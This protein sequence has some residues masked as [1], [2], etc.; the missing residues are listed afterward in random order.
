MVNYALQGQGAQAYNHMV[1]FTTN[2]VCSAW[3][4]YSTLPHRS[5]DCRVKGKTFGLT[6]A[7][8]G[9]QPGPYLVLPF[10]GPI[11][12]ARY[13]GLACGLAAVTSWMRCY[14]VSLRN[15]AHGLRLDRQAG[16]C[17]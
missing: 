15:A 14:P 11:H 7:R 2:T 9:M 8:W 6:L 10:W 13:R 4:G 5:T 16:Q 12:P 17:A 1:R 3:V